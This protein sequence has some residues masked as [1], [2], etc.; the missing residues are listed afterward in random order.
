[1]PNRSNFLCPGGL[2]H[3]GQS[4]NRIYYGGCLHLRAGTSYTG[5]TNNV[6][7]GGG[8]RSVELQT[9]INHV[10]NQSIMPMQQ[11]TIKILNI[12][13]Q[14]CFHSWQYFM[15][16]ITHQYQESNISWLHKDRTMDAPLWYISQTM[17]YAPFSL[18]N[19]NLYPFPVI[20]YNCQYFSFQ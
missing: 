14:G 15:C 3:T 2:V 17:S 19:L 20:N 7:Q 10:G 16:I 8:F 11:R 13:V 4:N 6:I 1:M 18:T 12:K 9:G 5:K